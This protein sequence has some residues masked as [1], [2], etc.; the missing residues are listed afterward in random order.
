VSV[1]T[2]TRPLPGTGTPPRRWGRWVVLAG[3]LVLV[4]AAVVLHSPWMSLQEVEILGAEHADV[5]ARV[6]ES[7][8][9]E[10][11]LMVWISPGEVE[12]AVVADP[13]VRE[14]RVQRLLPDRLVVEVLEHT[15]LLWVQ[16]TDAW[17]LVG[18]EGSV[19]RQADRP[20]DSLMRAALG[21]RDRA[22]GTRP[23]EPLWDEVV[24]LALVFEPEMAATVELEILG[25]EMWTTI[26]GV[27]VRLGPPTDLADKGRVLPAILAEGVPPGWSI[28]LVA[29]RRPVLVPPS[30][31]DEA[32]LR[33]GGD[34]GST[35]GGG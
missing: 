6:A 16:G 14:A 23:D 20:D 12:A 34:P 24:A 17:M 15:P 35:S 8:V 9:G 13:W 30:L 4:A 27:R 25:G 1:D 3:A 32:E 2:A 31:R 21:L 5:A 18:R 19:L 10:G 29:P 26:A 11:A 33:S 22:P 7:G 28:D